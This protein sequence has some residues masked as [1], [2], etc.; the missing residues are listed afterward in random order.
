M[1]RYQLAA[2]LLLRRGERVLE[3]R[4][5]LDSKTVVLEDQA[6][7][8]LLNMSVAKLSM[9]VL[10][11]AL[12]IVPT[13]YVTQSPKDAGEP[14]IDLVPSLDSLPDRYRDDL[15]RRRA[16]IG[17][18]RRNGLTRGM[19]RSIER[20]LAKLRIRLEPASSKQGV[21]AHESGQAE[22]RM[23][24][25]L[26][27][28][29]PSAVM[30]WWRDFELEGD[31]PSS[32]ISRNVGRRRRRTL[33]DFVFATVAEKLR[34][35]YCTRARPTLTSTTIEINKQLARLSGPATQHYQVSESTVR[36]ALGEIEPF[37]VDSARYGKVYARNKW[38]YSLAGVCATRPLER[39][40]IDHTL[41]D[42]VVVHDKTGMPL[43][44][45]TVTVVVDA[46]SGY[47]LGFFLS[48][49][50]TGLPATLS[51]I[52]Q[53]VLPKDDLMASLPGLTQPWLAWGIHDLWVVD[54][55]LE[56]HSPQ[57][58]LAAAEMGCDVLF[59]RVRQ[60]WLKPVVERT[61]L[62]LKMALPKEGLV[63]K[64]LTNELPLD[65]RKS[66]CVRFSDLCF[67]LLMAFVDVH[68]LEVNERRLARPI[69]LFGEGMAAM[70][71]PDLPTDLR[72]FDL[73][74]CM[75]K[76]LAV[77]NEGVVFQHLRFNSRDLQAIRFGTAVTYKTLVKF[78]PGDL[79]GVYVQ[80]LRS[81]HW[82]YVPSTQ[83]EYSNGLS[84]IQHR[85]I[86]QTL[87]DKL[88]A[89][90]VERQFL[91]AK[92][93]LA[94]IWADAV[95][96]GRKLKGLHLRALGGLTSADVLGGGAP[97]CP[98]SSDYL[99]RAENDDIA[100]H[101]PRDIPTFESFQLE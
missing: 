69:D 46:F 93:Q 67:A 11:R 24:L 74:G 96:V 13:H 41:L 63:I 78:Q 2:G 48:F 22:E 50:G 47:V 88:E 68:P 3:V 14:Q 89:R 53:A 20:C 34:T 77:G 86:R 30:K 39:V 94:E 101:A 35:H 84:L 6:T 40:E 60:P 7:G 98:M 99:A 81:K 8:A 61:M 51:A 80:D 15:L 19:R 79:S 54:N 31:A 91:A 90:N 9:E 64:G 23:R 43:G 37:A 87:K 26:P 38:R 72:S 83:P 75:S 97:S 70:P 16:Y 25:T 36:R 27:V 73:L 45:P 4:R 21:D 58:L 100:R 65:P 66:A 56:F 71:P 55:G 32:L 52:R 44:R 85:A 92:A 59:C 10:S 42:L 29:S 95:R 76:T 5:I 49:W 62:D 33:P 57:F 1:P 12:T 82:L 28:P 17:Y 18:L